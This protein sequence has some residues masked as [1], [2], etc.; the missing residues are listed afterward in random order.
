MA[1]F[2]KQLEGIFGMSSE[3]GKK[4][5]GDVAISDAMNHAMV[6]CMPLRNVVSYGMCGKQELL[7]M[8]EKM[9]QL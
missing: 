7:D 3:G 4:E 6:A 1:H 2:K 9:N 8:I 5:D